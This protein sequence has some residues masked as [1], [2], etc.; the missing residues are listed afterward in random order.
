[1]VYLQ[2]LRAATHLASPAVP[3]QNSPTEIAVRFVAE[4]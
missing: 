3:L 1:M 2:L 4:P